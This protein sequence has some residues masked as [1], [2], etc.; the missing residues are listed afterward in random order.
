MNQGKMP[1]PKLG[2]MMVFIDGENLV[3]R[4]QD[5]VSQ[6][7]IPWGNTAY[8]PDIYVFTPK[9]VEVG[10]NQVIRATYYTYAFGSEERIQE[11]CEEIKGVQYCQYY[12]PE[13]SNAS[14]L[15][16]SSLYPCVF[17]KIKGKKAKGVDIQL[18]VDIL[19]NVYMDNI[20]TVYLISG[21][22]DYKPVIEE[23]IRHGKNIYIAALSSG[24][25]NSLK[26]IADNFIDLDRVYFKPEKDKD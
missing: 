8:L 25:N 18:T 21:D 1:L 12:D 26:Y 6:G 9:S 23:V 15:L 10:L 24:L 4:Y 13:N 5:M 11:I 19:T 17:R 22:G 7:R 16:D 20:D 3:L 2:R 14:G